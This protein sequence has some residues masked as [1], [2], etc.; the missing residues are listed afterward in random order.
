M[1]NL[2]WLVVRDLFEIESATFWKNGPEIATG[3][4]VPEESRTEVFF[5]PAAS[6]VEKEGTFTQTQRLLQWR[7]KARRAA[8][9]CRSELWF[10]YHL[11]GGPGAAGRLHRAE[12]D[13]PLLDLTWDYPT[14]GA[15]RRAERRGGADARS[16]GTRSPPAVPLSSFT[17]MKDDGSTAG[18]CWIY[19]GVYADGVNQAAR[20][21]PGTEQSWVAPSGAGPGRRT[22]ASSTTAPRP[23]P[24]ASRGASARRYVWWDAE[25]GEWTGHDV[26][27]FETDKPPSY[28]PAGRRQR[29]EAHRRRRPVHHAGRRQGLAVRAAGPGRRADADPL[30]AGRVAVRATRCTASRPTPPARCTRTRQNR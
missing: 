6:H 21:K 16:T 17:E 23:T 25:P 10:F 27:D 7:E 1:A 15:R 2:D 11:A 22:A 13:R 5:L 14:H 28:R 18:G 3:E 9:D 8:G 30:R 19:T 20:R 12:R 29:A 24:R 4:I 26:P